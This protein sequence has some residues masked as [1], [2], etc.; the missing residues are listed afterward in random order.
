MKILNSFSKKTMAWFIVGSLVITGTV[1]WGS[2]VSASSILVN[3]SA[4]TVIVSDGECTLREAIENANTDSDITGGDCAPGSGTDTILFS[5]GMMISL[6]S[7]LPNITSP[8]I[9]DGIQDPLNPGF[10]RTGLTCGEHVTPTPKVLDVE[11]VASANGLHFSNLS[12]SGS[13]IKGLVIRTSAPTNGVGV[14]IQNTQNISVQC[15]I[16]GMNNTGNV[17]QGFGDGIRIMSSRNILIGG[18]NPGEG[19]VISGNNDYPNMIT[20]QTQIGVDRSRDITILG[21]IIGPDMNGAT[22]SSLG[23]EYGIIMFGNEN[24]IVGG[25]GAYEHNI[26][27]GMNS[28]EAGNET[29]TGIDIVQGT[30]TIIQGNYIGVDYTGNSPLPNNSQGI[31]MCDSNPI[32]CA[33]GT[34]LSIDTLIGGSNPDEGN[35][36]SGNPSGIVTESVEQL[37]I[38]GNMFGVGVDG[39]TPISMGY[40][41]AFIHGPLYHQVRIGGPGLYERNIFGNLI[42]AGA[43]VQAGFGESF[44]QAVVQNNY[45]GV[46]KN[47]DPAPLGQGGLG[48]IDANVLVGGSGPNEGNYFANNNT[49]GAIC[50][51]CTGISTHNQYTNNGSGIRIFQSTTTSPGL[52]RFSSSK[53]SFSN[54][55]MYDLDLLYDSDNDGSPDSAGPT[56]TNINDIGDIDTGSNSNLNYPVITNISSAGVID[57]YVDVPPGDY[58]VEFYKNAVA[59]PRNH[60]SGEVY[61]ATDTFTVTTPGPVFRTFTTTPDVT[62]PY[63]ASIITSCSPGSSCATLAD[64]VETSEFGSVARIGGGGTTALDYGDAPGTSSGLTA[65]GNY[66]TQATKNGAYH[67]IDTNYLGSCV[68]GDSGTLQNTLATADDS[69][70]SSIYTVGTCTGTNDEDGVTFPAYMLWGSSQTLPITANVAG[71]LNAWIDYNADGDFDDIGEQVS[72]NQSINPAD[73]LAF[74]VPAGVGTITTYARLRFVSAIDRIYSVSGVTSPYGEALDGEVEDY[75]IIVSDTVPIP[76]CTNPSA[77]NYNPLATIDDGSCVPPPPSGGGSSGGTIDLCLN[78]SGAQTTVPTG[79]IKDMPGTTPGACAPVTKNPNDPK[80]YTIN[81]YPLNETGVI[82]SPDSNQCPYF[83][84]YLKLGKKN[85]STEVI[86]WQNFL[87]THM[88]EKLTVNGTYNTETYNAVKRFQN[89]YKSDVLIPWGLKGPTGWTYKTTRMKANQIVGCLEKPVFLEIP[90]ITW[91]LGELKK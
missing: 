73:T 50:F 32:G 22:V 84:K 40:I 27:S 54:H 28:I 61:L 58:V 39:Q 87:N 64:Y 18:S 35:V 77:T 41:G 31:R 79:Y 60:G 90:K 70:P 56:E 3:S 45:F 2:H 57:Y 10:P 85:D 1:F 7:D 26:I 17:Q 12:A 37:S 46:D 75:R 24:V 29:G 36:I 14:T 69:L 9:I 33:I 19:N 53:D 82:P 78:I 81:I 65:T 21:N 44:D 59:G 43:V 91:V 13:Q 47:L 88:K 42:E 68:D 23:M 51:N 89:N 74:S 52:A 48:I 20:Y 34:G 71:I 5:N 6:L 49:V 16:V 15:S 55:A 80:K 76:G 11:I 72:S 25:S 38:L 67:I 62:K 8:I 4:D 30:H 63:I 83:T 86:K 66:N